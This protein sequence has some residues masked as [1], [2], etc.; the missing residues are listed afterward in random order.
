MAEA[1]R[2]A[3]LLSTDRQY[4]RGVLQGVA[5]YARLHG[6]WEL[7][8]EPTHAAG[9]MPMS[10]LRHLNG[11]MLMLTSRRQ[12]EL[13]RR[14][15]LPAV[16][17]SSRF[18]EEDFAHVSNDGA[19][20]A[21]LAIEHFIE[22][23]FGHFAFCDL[24]DASCYRRKRWE[25]ELASRGLTGHVFKVAA[26]QRDDW[27]L[28]R[29]RRRLEA[30][31]RKL[32][33]PIGILAHNDLRGRHVVDACRRLGIAMPD[34]VA[35]LGVDNELPHCEMCNPPLSSIVTD[36]ERIG[37]EAAALLQQL[38][39]GKRPDPMRILIPALGI[40]VRQ[41]S[42]VTATADVH[43]AKAV[44]YIREHAFE[45]IDVGDVLR[46]VMISRTA[47]DK[48]FLKALGHSPH[49]EIRRVRLKRARELLA[50]SHLTIEAIAER[51]GF[52][53]GEYLGAVFLQEF[54]QTPGD[55]RAQERLRSDKAAPSWR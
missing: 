46:E 34:E 48:R 5:R 10:R 35:V 11:V 4:H 49:E 3:V 13:L 8:S 54:G 53:H 45:G 52:R 25:Q 43:V 17:M 47:L 36:S 24:T 50:E 38:M 9:Q 20:I 2:V 30:W 28:G 14:W 22:R 29:D 23:G 32:P 40:V 26:A 31:L 7:E 21:R 51:C 19:S 44:R 16:N 1:R 42:D 33:K 12:I 18:P 27:V 41:S 55:F 39:D 37:F 15:N 6:P